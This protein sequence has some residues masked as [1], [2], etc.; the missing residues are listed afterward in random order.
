MPI[1]R[2]F[3]SD[4]P[5]CC[6]FSRI[7]LGNFRISGC[8]AFPASRKSAMA[9]FRS[10]AW[11]LQGSD[12]RCESNSGVHKI[13]E[14]WP[15]CGHAGD[16]VCFLNPF[17]GLLQL[18]SVMNPSVSGISMKILWWLLSVPRQTS[19]QT[20]FTMFWC[21]RAIGIIGMVNLRMVDPIASLNW[22]WLYPNYPSLYPKFEP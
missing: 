21:C 7:S 19:A 6:W 10:F 9:E 5:S 12:F 22:G 16:R 8:P 2:K 14:I 13:F 3:H 11:R 18:E 17:L 20:P 1:P 15:R 4:H